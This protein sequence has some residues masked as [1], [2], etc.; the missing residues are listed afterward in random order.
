MET[1][2]K[3]KQLEQFLNKSGG[4]EELQTQIGE[5][6]GAESMIALGEE[7]GCDSTAELNGEESDRVSGGYLFKTG[8]NVSRRSC[9]G[10]AIHGDMGWSVKLGLGPPGNDWHSRTSVAYTISTL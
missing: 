1:Y 6:I 8:V 9:E 7:D 2:H 3:Q 5:E 4:S 10:I